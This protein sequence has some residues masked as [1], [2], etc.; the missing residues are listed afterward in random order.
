MSL[1]VTLNTFMYNN[2]KANV[3][4]SLNKFYYIATPSCCVSIKL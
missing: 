3:G 4:R 1:H 2:N